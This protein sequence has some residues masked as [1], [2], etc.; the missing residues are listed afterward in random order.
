MKKTLV[1]ISC[2]K[3]KRAEKS[4]AQD[5]YTGE[6][7]KKIRSLVEKRNQPF[8]ILSA[9]HGLVPPLAEL[10]PYEYTLAGKS[11]SV[12]REWAAGVAEMFTYYSPEEWRI[13]I[14]AGRDYRE[15]LVPMMRDRGFE[16]EIPLEG[17]GIGEQLSFLKSA[18]KKKENL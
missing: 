15:F 8:H 9:L 11:K 14:F 16:V 6:L 2:G 3:I 4:A 12:K 18:L 10:D 5:L 17:L 7:F 13:E 1:L